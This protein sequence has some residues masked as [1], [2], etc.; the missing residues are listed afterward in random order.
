MSFK[1]FIYY[2]AVCGGWAGAIGWAIGRIMAASQASTFT[3]TLIRGT[4][5]GMMIAL[6]LGLLDGLWNHSSRQ[7]IKVV[8]Q[9]V[10]IGII[11]C[12]GSLIGPAMGESLYEKTQKVPFVVLGWTL[13]GLLIGASFGVYDVLIR[14]MQ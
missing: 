6:G 7:L 13:A 9:G 3:T 14:G 5:L 4:F 12:L 8:F 1:L 11:R 10:V 2:C